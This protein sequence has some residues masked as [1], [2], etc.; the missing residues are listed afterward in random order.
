MHE[1]RAA[2]SSSS[3]GVRDEEDGIIG[4]LELSEDEDEEGGRSPIS[5]LGLGGTTS[6][7]GRREA[8]SA[9]GLWAHVPSEHGGW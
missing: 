3:S 6:S 1:R 2:S 9:G 5:P 4:R 7:E 8:G